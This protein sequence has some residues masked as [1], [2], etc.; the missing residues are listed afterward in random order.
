MKS[1]RKSS[2]RG[3]GG[4]AIRTARIERLRKRVAGDPPN[5]ICCQRA[6]HMT[7]SYRETEG[8]PRIL[9]QAKAFRAV[10]EHLPVHVGED[11]LVVGIP[12]SKPRM[13]YFAPETFPRWDTVKPDGQLTLTNNK[14][15]DSLSIRFTVPRD[16]VDYWRDKPMG[17]SIG[18]LVPGYERVLRKGFRGILA[19]VEARREA[20]GAEDD[21]E[22]QMF[23]DAVAMCAEAA[24][25]F[26]E[27]HAARARELATETP[28]ARRACELREIADICS[29]VP[30]HSAQGFREALQ[31]FWFTHVLIHIASHDWSISPGRFDQ[32]MSPF[33]FADLERGALTR[34]EAAELLQ[35]LWIKFNELRIDLDFLN[36]QNLM[37]GGTDGGGDEIA[38]DFSRL[39]LEV[40]ASLHLVQ[41]SVS[42]RVHD[43]T[44]TWFLDLACETIAT[45]GGLPAMFGERA[46]LSALRRVGVAPEDAA[47]FAIAGCEETAL[48]ARLHG[49]LSAGAYNQAQCLIAALFN[50][51]DPLSGDRIGLETGAAETF[52]EFEH[53]LQAYRRQL[54]HATEQAIERSLQREAR[55][56]QYTPYP[57]LSMLFDDCLEKGLDI[58][59]G[60]V[61]Y[62]VASVGESGTITAANSLYAVKRAVY[63]EKWCAMAELLQALRDNW[64]GHEALRIRLL[65]RIP[66]FGNDDPDIDAFA[67]RIAGMNADCFEEIHARNYWGGPF[68]TGS[69]I[70]IAFSFGAHVAATPDGRFARE[71][72]SLSLGPSQGSDR[73]GPTALLQS[74]SKIDFSRQAGGA[75]LHVKLNPN[76]L[77]GP[78]GIRNFASL[79]RVFF[80]QGGMGLHVSVVDRRMLEEA[81]RCPEKHRDLYVRVGGYSAPFVLLAPELQQEMIAR[82]EH[83]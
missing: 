49:V 16:V 75:L 63:E 76:T 8:E 71:H 3:T 48:Q 17:V 43:R 7:R 72:V 20:P 81:R 11:E 62:Y 40:T 61:R 79:C 66:K 15:A 38:N 25:R 19:D 35:C 42:I 4:N 55:A 82:T 13:A 67:A 36:Y 1:T 77:A 32:Y 58:T 41:P 6:I 24:I 73:T 47:D 23:Y 21:G 10:C 59:A 64:D 44:P 57:F 39:C 51:V 45:G 12:T 30:A 26:A 60:G 68:A 31:S 78:N 37:L 28:D 70:S 14:L 83:R 54:R 56:A 27:R 9:R 34:E 69:G 2:R 22:K 80:R 18:H 53:L 33:Y 46:N 50:G 29:R 65:K 74:V 52:P 5:L